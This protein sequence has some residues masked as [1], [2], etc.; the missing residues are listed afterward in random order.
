MKRF[1]AFL[2]VLGFFVAV[3]LVAAGTMLIGHLIPLEYRDD[4]WPWLLV[5][6]TAIAAAMLFAIF[7]MR[8]IGRW[9]S[10]ARARARV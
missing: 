9:P 1:C 10:R 4:W 2:A 7:A 3:N 8:L 5:G 6:L